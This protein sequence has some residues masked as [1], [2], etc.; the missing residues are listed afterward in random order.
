MNIIKKICLYW[1]VWRRTLSIEEF[2][3][4]VNSAETSL[5]SKEKTDAKVIQKIL[6]FYF[7]HTVL[8]DD[9]MKIL[10]NQR[11]YQAQEIWLETARLK[12]S[13][14]EAEEDMLVRQMPWNTLRNFPQALSDYYLTVLF[15]ERNPYKIVAYCR[16]Y[17][18]SEKFEKILLEEYQK[19]LSQPDQK[20][21]YRRFT[22]YEL[23]GWAEALDVYLDGY[24]MNKKHFSTSDIPLVILKSN[25][26][27]LIE[28]LIKQ[29][30]IADNFLP[31]TCL[32]YLIEQGKEKA[33]R[34]LLCESYL[35]NYSLML[36]RLEKV[37]PHLKSALSIS[38]YRR[39]IYLLEQKHNVFLGALSLT[40]REHNIVCK[41]ITTPLED[42]ENF[43]ETYIQPLLNKFKPCMCA[44]VAYH[45]PQLAYL[46]EVTTSKYA[47]TC[48]KTYKR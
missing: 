21:T 10:C 14:T 9:E 47:E 32:W 38:R 15:A 19:S 6:K 23:N 12:K 3:F 45:F 37:Y 28:K 31:D 20:M 35:P 11:Y 25:D 40:P 48:F 18:L 29:C 33:L 39:E 43:E 41:H 4:C 13:L 16:K 8:C 1:K 42:I 22:Q 7:T 46:A 34:L 44:Y 30:S 27:N 24:R 2:S 17:S 5:F 36:L 26:N